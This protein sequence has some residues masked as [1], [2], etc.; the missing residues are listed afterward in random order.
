MFVTTLIERLKARY[1]L[2]KFVRGKGVVR[3]ETLEELEK[4]AL[5]YTGGVPTESRNVRFPRLRFAVYPILGGKGMLGFSDVSSNL[6]TPPV[7]GHLSL[8]CIFGLLIFLQGLSG[9]SSP[10]L[11]LLF[12]AAV[13]SAIRFT[14]MHDY[15]ARQKESSLEQSMT[16]EGGKLISDSV[17]QLLEHRIDRLRDQLVG[18]ES[19]FGKTETFVR[20]VQENARRLVERHR[21]QRSQDGAPDFLVESQSSAQSVL[22]R[23]DATLTRLQAFRSKVDAYL[24]ECLATATGFVASM[25][26]LELVRE[27]RDLVASAK[28]IEN[29]ATA[30]IQK[31]LD[32]LQ[33]GMTTL[34]LD[35][36]HSTQLA[37]RVAVSL[38]EAKDV[39]AELDQLEDALEGFVPHWPKVKVF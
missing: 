35:V 25:R 5:A 1:A 14:K 13:F 29:L 2:W 36:S 31:T 23:A 26:H 7:G 20:S 17:M 38:P 10:S 12:V 9:F 30:Q 37:H 4:A 8:S 18:D 39:Y 22:D 33:E 6:M 32:Q 27:T 34:H 3:S 24:D 19:S 11:G 21:I 28:E 16:D 15:I